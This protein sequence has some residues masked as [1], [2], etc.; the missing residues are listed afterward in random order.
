MCEYSQR[1]KSTASLSGSEKSETNIKH[2]RLS[3]ALIIAEGRFELPFFPFSEDEKEEGKCAG[4]YHRILRSAEKSHRASSGMW[5]WG[6]VH[7]SNGHKCKVK[8][9]QC[10]GCADTVQSN[11]KRKREKKSLS[12]PGYTIGVFRA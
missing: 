2:Q 4:M 6:S 10:L 8:E 5:S 3:T 12:R 11:K 9:N 1:N 7:T